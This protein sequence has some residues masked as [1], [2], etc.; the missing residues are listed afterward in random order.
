MMIIILLLLL[1]NNV[2]S[3]KMIFTHYMLAYNDNGQ[4][5]TGYSQEMKLAKEYG[6]DA[7]AVNLAS[8]DN[9]DGPDY[10]KLANLM[11]DA[12]DLVSFKLFFCV[13]MDGRFDETMMDSMLQTYKNRPSYLYIDSRMVLNTFSGADKINWKNWLNNHNPPIYF[14]PSFFKAPTDLPN[15]PMDAYVSWNVWADGGNP[16]HW[17]DHDSVIISNLNKINADYVAGVSPWFSSYQARQQKVHGNHRFLWDYRW[18]EIIKNQP[19]YVYITTW[20]DF[21]ESTYI[22]PYENGVAGKEW[23][24]NR[25]THIAF[26]ELLKYYS[27]AYKNGGHPKTITSDTLYYWYRLSPK[28]SVPKQIPWA[29]PIDSNFMDDSIYIISI[30]KAPATIRITIGNKRYT[31][32][33]GS[34]STRISIPMSLGTP[35]FELIRDNITILNFNGNGTIIN[36]P[37]FYDFDVVTGF[38]R[39]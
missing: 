19:P 13:D 14:M 39:N 7:F 6:I 11:F 28:N 31:G 2:F 26:L 3:Q 17:K 30:L 22:A 8:W 37:E 29:K 24:R 12:A 10:V 18:R 5:I 16:F 38:S 25:Y 35:K 4:T 27:K 33:I 32:K 23:K 34:R 36:D 9:K 20:N 21:S 1:V 15:Y